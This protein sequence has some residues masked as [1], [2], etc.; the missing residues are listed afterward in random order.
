[1]SYK[2]M[3]EVDETLIS[4]LATRSMTAS[5]QRAAMR[6]DP[7][8]LAFHINYEGSWNKIIAVVSAAFVFH[9]LATY[10]LRD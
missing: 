9:L 3:I 2:G 5:A 7:I 4:P 8:W 1:M 10:Q 6:A